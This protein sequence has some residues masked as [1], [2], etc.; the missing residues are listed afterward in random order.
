[1]QGKFQKMLVKQIIVSYI[2]VVDKFKK[3][4][5]LMFYSILVRIK[6]NTLFIWIIF[7]FNILH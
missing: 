3:T 5:K 6:P 1:M 2:Y 4:M 7:E